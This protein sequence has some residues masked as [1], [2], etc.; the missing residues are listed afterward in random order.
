MFFLKEHRPEEMAELIRTIAICALSMREE[1]SEVT[2]DL[3]DRFCDASHLEEAWDS[4]KIPDSTLT[5]FGGLF[6]FSPK[7]LYSNN[8][9]EEEENMF[10]KLCKGK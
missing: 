8:L 1:L 2:F 10:P 4:M 5:F 6:N 3:K 9:G 7:Y